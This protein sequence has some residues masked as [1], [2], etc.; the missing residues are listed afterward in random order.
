MNASSVQSNNK[1]NYE[2]KGS[3]QPLVL[4]H[5]VGLDLTMWEGIVAELSSQ[6]KIITFDLFGNGNSAHPEGPYSLSKYANQLNELLQELKIEKAHILGFSLG[7][8]VAMKFALLYS[9]K[10]T[11]IVVVS[12]VSNRTVEERAI[13]QLRVKKT[14]EEGHLSV[15][16]DSIDRWFDQKFKAQYPEVVNRFRKRLE[17]NEQKGYLASYRVYANGDQELKH[18]LSDIKCP[19]LVMTGGEDPRSH[20][21]MAMYMG[22][23]ISNSTVKIIP[24]IR[25]MLPI[26]APN[27]FNQMV[28]SFLT[29]LPE[30]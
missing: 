15:V 6:F 3:G 13:I 8:L 21:K 28:K 7:G 22:E 17:A 30:S 16:D 10:T 1:T 27:E 18:Q 5:G 24:G 29:S 12:A 11:S 14:E 9:Q 4:I 26:E 25:H 2:V 23:Q 19:A 20:T